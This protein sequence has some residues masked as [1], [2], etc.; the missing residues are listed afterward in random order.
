MPGN[1]NSG[2]RPTPTA[3]KVIT[4]NPGKRPLPENEPQ[5]PPIDL[6]PPEH[7]GVSATRQWRKTA[8]LLAEMKILT[9]ADRDTFAVYCETVAAWL[10]AKDQ[11][12]QSGFLV[13]DGSR[14]TINPLVKLSRNLANDL[15]RIATE[16]GMTP[17]A[18][19]RLVVSEQP[20]AKEPES[21]AAVATQLF[22]A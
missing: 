22:G 17:T 10:D 20:D 13:R 5:A 4:G 3:L 2:R 8:P 11:V 15:M 12:V 18:R 7:L 16:F 1:Q 21:D 19:S 9:Q 6:E 14:I